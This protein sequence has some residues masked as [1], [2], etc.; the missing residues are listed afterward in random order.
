MTARKPYRTIDDVPVGHMD[1]I[2][3]CIKRKRLDIAERLARSLFGQIQE[4]PVYQM[5]QL[6]TKWF[7]LAAV[8]CDPKSDARKR[9]RKRGW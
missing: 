7:Q 8:P 3:L 9:S 4:M 5:Y 1:L 2:V 6:R